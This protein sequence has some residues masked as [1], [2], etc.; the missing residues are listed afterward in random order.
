MA[1]SNTRVPEIPRAVILT[2]HPDDYQAIRAHLTDLEEETHSQG[3]VYELGQL[4][5]TEQTWEVA[6]TEVN[7]ETCFFIRLKKP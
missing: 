7:A 5:A 4:S 6:I 3:T 2:A 1:G